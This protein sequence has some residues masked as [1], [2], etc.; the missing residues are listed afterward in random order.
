M[1]NL[2]ILFLLIIHFKKTRFLLM[3]SEQRYRLLVEN[4]SD[5]M[6]L[7]DYKKE[8]FQYISPSVQPLLGISAAELYVSPQR[9]FEKIDM[10]NQNQE[11]LNLFQRPI[12]S[13]PKHCFLKRTINRIA[14]ARCIYLPIMDALG[15]TIAVEGIL[16]TLRKESK[17][18]KA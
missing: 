1:V 2:L 6:F 12:R 11:L 18:K 17:S 5:S 15:S 9:F 10:S 7:Y 8:K 13:L 14:G 3:K 4:S 16:G